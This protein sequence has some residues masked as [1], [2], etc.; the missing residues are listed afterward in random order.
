MGQLTKFMLT[1]RVKSANKII[2]SRA[3]GENYTN[4]IL[5]SLAALHFF[6]P[7]LMSHCLGLEY[8]L[9]RLT[10]VNKA[11]GKKRLHDCK[12]MN[13]RTI[14]DTFSYGKLS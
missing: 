11:Q 1:S 2:Q 8:I 14:T 6:T 9:H 13:Q 5:L 10:Y 12:N 7:K 4:D 3:C